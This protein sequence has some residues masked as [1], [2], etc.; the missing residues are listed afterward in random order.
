MKHIILM[1]VLI[2]LWVILFF[3]P[4]AYAESPMIQVVVPQEIAS[5]PIKSYAYTQVVYIYGED[6]WKSFNNIIVRESEWNPLNQ[7]P[8]STAFGLMQFLDSTW[9]GTGY[10]KTTD[11]YYQIDAGIKYISDR[12]NNPKEA[13]KWWVAHNWY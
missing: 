11:P 9:K 8:K 10:K 5:D 13:W 2:A 1:L 3:I 4:K 6:H 12:Y 7:N